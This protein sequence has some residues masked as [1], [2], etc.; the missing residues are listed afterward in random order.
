MYGIL[1]STVPS[2]S[3]FIRAITSSCSLAVSGPSLLI[4]MHMGQRA[5]LLS[6]SLALILQKQNLALSLLI[7]NTEKDGRVIK[8]RVII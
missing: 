6:S 2:S 8:L 1:G 7:D 3:K 5:D 4:F